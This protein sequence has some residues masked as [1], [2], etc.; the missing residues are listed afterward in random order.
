MKFLITG[1]AGF[2][3]STLC[4]FLINKGN[5]VVCFDNFDT[6]YS[7]N[8]K[9]D[10]IAELLKH[11]NFSLVEGDLI[12]QESLNKVFAEHK[13]DLVIHLAA[14][15]GVRPSIMDPQAYVQVNING[16]MNLLESMKKVGAKNFVF[17][18]SS[19]VYG[20][21]DKIPYSE[22]DNV[23]FPI[24]PY[25]AT[26]KGGELLTFTYHHLHQFNV[27]NLRFFTVFGPRQR[28]DLAIHKFF[29]RLYNN[30]EIE[31]YGDGST[32]RDYTY[33]DDIISGIDAASD[34]LLSA[35]NA[36]YE[37]INLGNSSPIQLRNLIQLIEEVCD[38]KFSIKQMPMQEGDVDR[39]FADIRKA[40]ELLNYSPQTDMKNGLSKFK[41]WYE[42][43]RK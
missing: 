37:T 35:P 42:S 29:D 9:L 20:N 38:K 6:F 11:P 31:M 33:I 21:N 4:E 28:P 14:K 41:A 12:N 1:G 2:I 19:S 3:G 32:S 39:T 23:D 5:Q 16:T 7:K 10:N 40:K 25:A 27:V 22:T 43:R 26:K 34:L 18:S 8:T 30:Q 24:S 17:S 15:A 13:V 36:I